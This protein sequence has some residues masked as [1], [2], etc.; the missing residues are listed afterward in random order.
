MPQFFLNVDCPAIY[1]YYTQY[2]VL[3]YHDV[4]LFECGTLL[5]I[6]L[7]ARRH[8]VLSVVKVQ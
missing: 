8:K 6:A 7:T 2:S 5:T 1:I 3:T 4:S